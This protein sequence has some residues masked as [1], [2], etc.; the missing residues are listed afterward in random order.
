MSERK[1]TL[2]LTEDELGAIVLARAADGSANHPPSHTLSDKL[3][4]AKA[5][6]KADRE[7]DELRLPW[8][9]E[10][11][12]SGIAPYVRMVFG[13][14]SG[15]ERVAIYAPEQV[16]RL[17]SAA[18]ELLEAAKT[19]REAFHCDKPDCACCVDAVDAIDRALRKVESGVPEEP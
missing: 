11:V 15:S 17:M 4:A 7:A 19:A 14:G 6:A 5:K 13:A 9:I 1:Y 10:R 8:R 2:E 3:Y 12:D 16:I 18:P